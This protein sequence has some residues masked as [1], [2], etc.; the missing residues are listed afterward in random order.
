M[1]EARFELLIGLPNIVVEDMDCRRKPGF[2][3]LMQG[4]KMS[5]RPSPK[6]R[7]TMFIGC[8]RPMVCLGGSI[9][10]NHHTGDMFRGGCEF[11][12]GPDLQYASVQDGTIPSMQK[13]NQ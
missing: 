10:E 8:I 2:E 13:A 3:A 1:L 11:T 6:D 7:F 12:N 5:T 9:C 4:F